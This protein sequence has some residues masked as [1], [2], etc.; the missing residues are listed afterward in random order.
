MQHAPERGS[1][2]I[3]MKERSSQGIIRSAIDV[4]LWAEKTPSVEQV[5]PKHCPCCG[6]ASRPIGGSVVLQGHGTRERQI[7]GPLSVG[8]SSQVSLIQVRRYRCMRCQTV[9]TVAPAEVLH[10]RLYGASVIAL[11][12]ALFGLVYLSPWQTRQRV[13]PW[14]V[15]GDSSHGRW[16]TLKRW[17]QAAVQGRLWRSVKGRVAEGPMRQVAHRC[18]STLAGYA[19]PSPQPVP[20]VVQVFH[21]AARA[22]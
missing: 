13:S 9:V 11:A 21:G 8:A 15:V 18:A 3:A 7:W 10:K 19:L 14:Q 2:G 12:L 22:A 5:R 17:C 16:R 4:K 20:L 1:A 6:A